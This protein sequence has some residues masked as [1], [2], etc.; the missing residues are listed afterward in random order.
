[1][2]IK[3]AMD[4]IQMFSYFIALCFLGSLALSL[5]FAYRSGVPVPYI[6]ALFTAV[7]AVCVTGLSTVNMSV[8][9]SSG[10]IVLALLIESGG[11]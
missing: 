8:F 2:R 1:M 6:D 10:F 4:K 5:P 11:L 9:S 7:S 3:L